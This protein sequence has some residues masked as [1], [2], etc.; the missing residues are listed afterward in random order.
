MRGFRKSTLNVRYWMNSGK[1]MLAL[2]FSA[3]DPKRTS[4]SPL[5]RVLRLLNMRL[6]PR[7]KMPGFPPLF[8]PDLRPT[9]LRL[10]ATDLAGAIT[11]WPLWVRLGWLHRRTGARE[12]VFQQPQFVAPVKSE[13]AHDIGS[14]RA[15]NLQVAGH[16]AQTPQP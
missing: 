10:S 8:E 2:S 9:P 14:H 6:G 7:D 5:K 4:P 1:H 11:L 13:L 12:L 3:L 15:A 16:K